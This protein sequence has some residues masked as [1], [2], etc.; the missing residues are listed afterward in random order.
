MRMLI[1]VST[2]GNG[3][4]YEVILDDSITVG[5]AIV[6]IIE[7]INMLENGNIAFDETASLFSSVTQTRLT[8]CSSLRKA[9]VCS[10]QSLYLL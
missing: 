3:K 1:D 6:K 2:P 7:Q 5:V 4:N 9:G 10:G 8:D